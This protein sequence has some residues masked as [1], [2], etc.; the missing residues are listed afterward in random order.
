VKLPCYRRLV[1][2]NRANLIGAVGF[3]TPRA[4]TLKRIDAPP[5]AINNRNASACFMVFSR[6]AVLLLY[7]PIVV[8]A[9]ARARNS[10]RY[11]RP[12]LWATMQR[13]GCRA[14][15]IFFSLGAMDEASRCPSSPRRLVEANRNPI[16]LGQ[17]AHAQRYFAFCAPEI[18]IDPCSL[19][20]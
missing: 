2:K 3:G 17:I 19:Q 10:R 18:V 1:G 20:R 13:P 9:L 4:G 12:G 14:F 7:P 15:R 11:E 6:G 5:P 16:T 8:L